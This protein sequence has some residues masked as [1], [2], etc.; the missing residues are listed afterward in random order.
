MVVG[1]RRRPRLFSAAL[2]RP[3]PRPPGC[4]TGLT[5]RG[6]SGTADPPV[7]AGPIV[8]SFRR[9]TTFQRVARQSIG[10]LSRGFVPL[11][12]LPATP[13][14]PGLPRPGRSRSGVRVV[15]TS[16][17]LRPTR[18]RH[19]VPAVF[20]W[21][22]SAGRICM[23]GAVRVAQPRSAD[24]SYRRFGTVR[25]IESACTVSIVGRPRPCHTNLRR[26][27]RRAS[28]FLREAPPAAGHAPAA[29][30]LEP[31][32]RYPRDLGRLSWPGRVP[33]VDATESVS[34]PG[35]RDL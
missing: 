25:S 30:S 24:F 31:A 34:P 5:G 27:V 15:I 16:I 28:P 9:A 14:C 2:R 33:R 7:V 17:P 29:F 23:V 22:L 6:F 3:G 12:R 10:R 20:R 19:G 21:R 8:S 35:D 32:F 26:H 13:R 4:A 1:S 11:Q 18:W